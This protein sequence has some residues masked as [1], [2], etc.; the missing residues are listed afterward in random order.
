MGSWSSSLGLFKAIQYR[1]V[2]NTYVIC[3]AYTDIIWLQSK[4]CR[5]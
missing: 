1:L 4:W 5:L 2:F 3:F